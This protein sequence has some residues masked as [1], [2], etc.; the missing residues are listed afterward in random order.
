MKLSKQKQWVETL[1]CLMLIP[2]CVK[3]VVAY[4]KYNGPPA[5]NG[6]VDGYVSV[7][8]EKFYDLVSKMDLLGPGDA[9]FDHVAER[10]PNMEDVAVGLVAPRLAVAVVMNEVNVEDVVDA[11]EPPQCSVLHTDNL[12]VGHICYLVVCDESDNTWRV[13]L[14]FGMSTKRPGTVICTGKRKFEEVDM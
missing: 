9:A 7:D 12:V 13:G 8:D 5:E 14:K 11:K 4:D 10:L 1:L 6:T 2:S 3:T